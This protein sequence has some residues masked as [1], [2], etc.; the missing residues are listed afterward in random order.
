[1]SVSSTP[2]AIKVSVAVTNTGTRPGKEVVQVYYGAPQGQLGKAVKSLGAYAKTNTL[3]PG[4]TENISMTLKAAN[5][6]SYD[7]AGKTGHKSAWVLEAGDYPIYVGNSVRDATEEGVFAV[8]SLRVVEQLVE[9]VAPKTPFDRF[10]ASE[11]PDGT[12]VLSKDDAV[13]TTTA[14]AVKDRLDAVI[15]ALP[16]AAAF[17]LETWDHVGDA[18]PIQLIDVYEDPSLMDAFIDQ[19]SLEEMITLT[20]GAGT[21][22]PPYS[23][24][25]SAGIYAGYTPGLQKFGIP[26][27]TLNDGPSGIRISE[28]ATLL[29]IGTLLAST[30]NDA[31][32]EELYAGVGAEM[33]LNGTSAILAPGMNIHRDPL[34]GRNFEY[35][36]EDPLLAGQMGAAFTRGIQSQGVGATP[37]HY[38]ANNQETNRGA[39]DSQVSERALREIYL[40]AFEITVKAGEPHNIMTSYNRINGQYNNM[41]WQL[42]TQILRNEWGFKGVVMTDWGGVSGNDES[43]LPGEAGRVRSGIDILESGNA[44]AS[45][46]FCF[47]GWGCFAIPG[48]ETMADV[49]EVAATPAVDPGVRPLKVAEVRTT[50][51]RL[52][53]VALKSEIFRT[54]HHLP[55]YSYASGEYVPAYRVFTVAQPAQAKAVADMIYVGGKALTGF[56]PNNLDYSVFTTQWASL[57]EVTAIGPANVMLSITQATAASPI[58]TV[59]V[60]A[61]DGAES[62]YRVVFTNQASRP[63]FHPSDI[64]GDLSGIT[65][66]GAALP[67]FYRATYDYTVWVADAAAAVVEPVAPAGV[68]ATVTRE[69]DLV[70]IRSES[71]TQAREYRVLVGQIDPSQLPRSDDFASGAFDPSIWTVGGET[72]ASP[73]GTGAATVV[74]EE[75][76]WAATDQADLKNYLFQPAQ[77]DWTAE[78]TV[79]YDTLP[80]G[81]GASIGMM[82]Y[83][84]LD[85]Y[86]KVQLEGY[87]AVAADTTSSDGTRFYVRNPLSGSPNSNTASAVNALVYDFWTGTFIQSN[88]MDPADSTFQLRIAKAG[89]TYTFA[90]KTA[91]GVW[92][93][94]GGT[95]TAAMAHPKLALYAT[96]VPGGD[97]V[98][99]T[100]GPLVV[101]GASVP[102]FPTAETTAIAPSAPT[103]VWADSR[104]AERG[105]FA[106]TDDPAAPGHLH[107][108]G[109]EFNNALYNVSVSEA[110]YYAVSPRVASTVGTNSKW[111]FFVQVDGE[112]WAD[113]GGVG[114]TAPAGSTLPTDAWQDLDAKVVYLTPGL[115]KLR[116]HC[117]TTTGFSLS[118]FTVTPAVADRDGL[119]TAITAAEGTPSAPYTAASWKTVSTA[120]GAAH[121]AFLDAAATQ[122][123]LDGAAATLN[124][125]LSGLVLKPPSTPS[126]VLPPAVTFAG[127]TAQYRA[128]ATATGGAWSA[129]PDELAFQWL[130][131]GAPIAG[132]TASTYTPGVDDVGTK[133]S[134]QVTA[135]VAGQEDGVFVTAG[136]IVAAGEAPKATTAPAFSAAPTV[137]EALSVTAG[138]W[139]PA[140]DTVVYRW[141]VD[142]AELLGQASA[143]YTPGASDAGKTI[144]VIVQASLLG[145]AVGS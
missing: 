68:T 82:V 119:L 100:F 131:N 106:P 14:A 126:I 49:M 57:P 97:P 115:H 83:D 120:L 10:H 116:L 6:A 58:A 91:A 39:N 2:D 108:A 89:E 19:M 52:M 54:A 133:L 74:S 22:D 78:V 67:T 80:V 99:A 21:M 11:G 45:S 109:G 77:G 130:R 128:E 129:S 114:G 37:K 84:T 143:T 20:S 31:L 50:V 125:A 72:P 40:K 36:S 142:G 56:T 117:W 139:S 41:H 135:S 53:N 9:T 123:Q 76:Q 90:I 48:L 70:T 17:G 145:H 87:T 104:F 33:I 43:G 69:G 60:R 137:G 28:S 86:V 47:P 105:S 132:A 79:G 141:F 85:S 73:L 18:A 118:A 102:V 136:A 59:Y 122:G 140:P 121:A 112:N 34:C 92:T 62:R 35:F 95:Q 107:F 88:P 124:G 71:A 30:W 24:L 66:D 4:A 101:T 26:P 75:S 15:D 96:H 13:P 5:L 94:I 81:P 8:P 61:A 44:Y 63:V 127:G 7:D 64:S 138:S 144:S 25:G 23:V 134:V 32:V 103:T 3:A 29:P 1:R 16:S 12:I 65:I 93:A 46:E 113:W 110:G 111:T 55:T 98:T 27:L 42:V 51:E 38:A